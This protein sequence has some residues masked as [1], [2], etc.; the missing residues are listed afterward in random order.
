MKYR[1]Q[2]T[3]DDGTSRSVNV[4][5]DD[6]AGALGLVL[7]DHD[8]VDERRSMTVGRAARKPRSSKAAPKARK[9]TV[10]RAAKP[11][12]ATPKPPTNVIPI[13][14]PPKSRAP[15]AVSAQAVKAS[16]GSSSRKA[17]L[18]NQGVIDGALAVTQDTVDDELLRERNDYAAG[19]RK[20]VRD[21]GDTGLAAFLD[22]LETQS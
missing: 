16:G 13:T 15:K 12:K 3:D 18:W 11:R 4:T 7:D 20:G 9:A 17:L 14:R 6:A 22:S 2:Y 1:V 10:K 19:Y 8:D 5:A 21:Q